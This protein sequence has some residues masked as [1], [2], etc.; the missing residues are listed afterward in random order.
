MQVQQ[1]QSGVLRECE[2]R[3][4]RKGWIGNKIKE[5]HLREDVPCGFM[6]CTEHQH[7][8]FGTDPDSQEEFFIVDTHTL[9][10]QTDILYNSEGIRNMIVLQS[11]I[12]KLRNYNPQANERNRRQK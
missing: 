12:E 3:K 10:H 4:T 8:V 9:I 7:S 5:V 6:A 11:S 1:W 2:L